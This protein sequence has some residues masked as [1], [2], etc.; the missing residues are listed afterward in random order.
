M[1]LYIKEVYSL[2]QKCERVREMCADKK[3]VY[4]LQ[5]KLNRG[6]VAQ[7]MGTTRV[8]SSPVTDGQGANASTVGRL[9][10][11]A[12]QVANTPNYMWHYSLGLVFGDRR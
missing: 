2:Q 4:S 5:Q 3:E 11:T 6:S 8:F 7:P 9:Q 1:T 10:G 12:V